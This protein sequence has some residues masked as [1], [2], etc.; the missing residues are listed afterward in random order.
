MRI[1]YLVIA[2]NNPK[3]LKKEIMRLSSRNC[4]FFVHIDK[5]SSIEEFADIRGENVQ[6]TESRLPVYW[7]GFCHVHAVRLVLR[8]A[9]RSLQKF[10]YFVLQSGSDYPLRSDKYIQRFFEENYGA[11]FMNIIRIP[12][13]QGGVPL[14]KINRL[15]FDGSKPWRQLGSR[16]LAKAGL[17]ERDYREHLGSL[18]PYAGDGWW[19]LSRSAC[20]YVLEFAESNPHVEKYFQTT[21][22]PDEMFFHTI[23]GNS[24]FRSRIRRGLFYLDWTAGGAHPAAISEKHLALFEGRDRV[25]L[26]DVWGTGEALFTRKFSDRRLDLVDRVEEMIRRKDGG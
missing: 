7:G 10:D 18:E 11:E 8:E 17:G 2:Y 25:L 6:F 19:A 23:L 22:A 4:A 3:L 26:D 16:V 15:W 24:P 13:E 14:S 5:K 12:S 21:L 1:A 20:E 9:L